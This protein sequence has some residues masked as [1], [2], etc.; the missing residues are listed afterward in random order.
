MRQAIQTVPPASGAGG[1]TR[2]EIRDYIACNHDTR[3]R[4][5][6]VLH[7]AIV[8]CLRDGTIC[9]RRGRYALSA[10]AGAR[11]SSRVALAKQRVVPKNV[12]YARL[13]PHPADMAAYKW[14]CFNAATSRLIEQHR[15][16]GVFQ[17][18]PLNHFAVPRWS[19]GLTLMECEWTSRA[20]NAR[21]Q[22]TSRPSSERSRGPA[23]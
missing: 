12:K 4:D 14:R 10:S 22:R 6:H 2:A 1:L 23:S 7:G 15:L 17:Y 3:A 21:P 5:W 11:L 19:V 8:K 18:E 20:W 13:V 9:V 16:S